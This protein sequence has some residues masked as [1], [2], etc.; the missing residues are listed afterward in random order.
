MINELKELLNTNVVL[1]IASTSQCSVSYEGTLTQVN[2]DTDRF[3]IKPNF[4][5]VHI[6]SRPYHAPYNKGPLTLGFDISNISTI[7]DTD[8]VIVLEK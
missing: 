5:C 6:N 7:D 8:N 4:V 1:Q 2:E 3:V